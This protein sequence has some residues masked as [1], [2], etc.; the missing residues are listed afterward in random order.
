MDILRYF[1]NM[2]K[3]LRLKRDYKYLFIKKEKHKKALQKTKKE[4]PRPK[5]EEIETDRDWNIDTKFF[6][7][8]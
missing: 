5:M 7:M 3:H 4:Q 8:H 2:L 6:T 1:C